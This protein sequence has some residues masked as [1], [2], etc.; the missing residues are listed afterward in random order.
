M[1]SDA[2]GSWGWTETCGNRVRQGCIA[3]R[4]LR[5]RILGGHLLGAHAVDPAPVVLQVEES[6]A[7]AVHGAPGLMRAPST[8][9]LSRV[10]AACP[11]EA[12]A[13]PESNWSLGAGR[14]VNT[15]DGRQRPREMNAARRPGHRA[16]LSAGGRAGLWRPGQRASRA[17]TDCSS[18]SWEAISA[19]SSVSAD[20]DHGHTEVVGPVLPVAVGG[21]DRARQAPSEGQADSIR[22]AQV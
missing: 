1:A 11:E 18:P 6:L 14:P 10:P 21:V 16:D 12:G 22:Q 5:S 2:A 9:G 20:D 8:F 7:G 19:A 13:R 4:V 15:E 3:L 17:R